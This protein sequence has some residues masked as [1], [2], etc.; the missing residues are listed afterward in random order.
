MFSHTFILWN[1]KKEKETLNQMV[2]CRQDRFSWKKPPRRSEYRRLIGEGSQNNTSK[3]MRTA[4][5]R[6][7]GS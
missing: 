3:E 1:V 6:V 5:P 2:A 7:G 4:G